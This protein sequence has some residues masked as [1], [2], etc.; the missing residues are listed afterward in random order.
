MPRTLSLTPQIVDAVCA[1]IGRGLEYPDA[2]AAV[3]IPPS[4]R[5]RW[6]RRAH[7]REGRTTPLLDELIKRIETAGSEAIA[8]RMERYERQ[9]EERRRTHEQL[10][11]ERMRAEIW[12]RHADIL[13]R[14]PASVIPPP[15]TTQ[16]N[17]FFTMTYHGSDPDRRRDRLWSRR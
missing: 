3:G 7:G 2:F 17:Q 5:T 15:V 12:D 13:R 8:A 14:A 10:R 9:H 6:L 11:M 16:G 1:G 4:T